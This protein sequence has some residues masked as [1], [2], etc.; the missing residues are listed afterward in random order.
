MQMSGFDMKRWL[1]TTCAEWASK[2]TTKSS[3]IDQLSEMF[4][5]I[6]K[7]GVNMNLSNVWRQLFL[8]KEL[9]SG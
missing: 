8:E 4:H 3:S 5:C 1:D 2:Q 6:L 7:S 9:L